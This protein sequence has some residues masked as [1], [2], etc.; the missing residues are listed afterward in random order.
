MHLTKSPKN[1]VLRDEGD[2]QKLINCFTSNVM[3][4]P[5]SDEAG[6]ELFNFA[7]GVLLPT[8]VVDNLLSSTEKGREQMDMFVKQRL[9][10]SEV[11][12]WNP[13]PNLKVKSFSTMAKKTNV[14]ANDK[15]ITVGAD[16]DLFGRLLIAAN[17][18]EINLKEVLSYEL[19]AVPL[20][21]RIKMAVSARPPKVYWL[22][23]L[24]IKLKSYL[25]FPPPQH[26]K[27]STY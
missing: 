23:C 20:H 13:V 18:R 27:Q 25:A 7:T 5:F 10:T 4:D 15:V 21:L 3:T 26:L 16:R 12:F 22:K 9:E 24:K 14:K 8:N 17:T 11:N 19:S 1:R 2:V 6:G